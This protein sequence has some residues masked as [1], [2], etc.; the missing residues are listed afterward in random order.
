[1]K[2]VLNLLLASIT[3]FGFRAGA[4]EVDGGFWVSGGGDPLRFYFAEGKTL[5]QA[6]LADFRA[7]DLPATL[8]KPAR[9]WLLARR[10]EMQAD[11]GPTPLEWNAVSTQ[12]TCA[13]T[14]FRASAKISL[15]L[16]PC[17][18]I[19]SPHEA[20]K[21]LLHETTHHLGLRDE[22]LAD[23][24]A[25]G[26]AVAY[27]K[28]SLKQVTFCGTSEH[29][30][31]LRRL[32]GTWS[33]DRALTARLGGAF[34]GF[35]RLQLKIEPRAD[36]AREFEG[37]GACALQSGVL[38]FTG[39]AQEKR[40]PYLIAAKD[41]ALLMIHPKLRGRD[42]AE[43]AKARYLTLTRAENSADDL[44]F[45]GNDDGADVSSAF[46]RAH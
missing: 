26:A 32:A 14:D 38:I 4:A 34:K 27:A 37:F 13:L 22:E 41:G 36:M 21:L 15:S 28:T 7:D 30:G 44:L 29:D 1:M 25:I 9:E 43:K 40:L 6:I 24:I 11:L 39:G 19:A 20:A 2:N 16:E 5:A 23:E 31:V 35:A 18:R 3:I 42:R 17:R 8:S 45:I 12:I 33:L 10:A 46:Q